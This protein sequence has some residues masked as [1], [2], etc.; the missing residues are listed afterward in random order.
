MK[1]SPV[2]LFLG[3]SAALLVASALIFMTGY[4]KYA[5][6]KEIERE[7]EDL[8][9]QAEQI[10]GEKD[11]LAERIAYL[12]TQ[13]FKERE[14]KEKLNLKKPDEAVVIIKPSVQGDETSRD[15]DVSPA[16]EPE[17]PEL[18]N[19]MKWWNHFFSVNQN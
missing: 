11:S 12:Q 15:A 2:I 13:E 8:K 9:R 17:K 14:A 18:S 3:I 6:N 16:K 19:R 5:K 4:G 10:S 7:I 1:R